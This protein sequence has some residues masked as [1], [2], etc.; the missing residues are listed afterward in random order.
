MTCGMAARSQTVN[1]DGAHFS[2]SPIELVAKR[3]VST[4]SE[5][6]DGDDSVVFKWVSSKE[7]KA[8]CCANRFSAGFSAAWHFSCVA[9]NPTWDNEHNVAMVALVRSVNA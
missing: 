4:L 8:V 2:F 5:G 7:V 3:H 9:N 1:D 6:R